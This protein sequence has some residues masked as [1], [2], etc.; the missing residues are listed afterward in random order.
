MIS[1]VYCGAI[2]VVQVGD[3]LPKQSGSMQHV[4]MMGTSMRARTSIQLVGN[5]AGRLKA[6]GFGLYDMSGSVLERVWDSWG[7]EYS[8][9]TTDPAYDSSSSLRV[10]RGGGF[11]LFLDGARVFNRLGDEAYTRS[12]RIFVF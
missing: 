4:V 8:S 1:Q 12:P 5:E 3:C 2:E 11:A 7:R 9:S 6:N 10:N